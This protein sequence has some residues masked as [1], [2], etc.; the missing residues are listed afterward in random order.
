MFVRGRHSV[1]F[2]TNIDVINEVKSFTSKSL[3]T[4]DLAEANLVLNIKLTRVGLC[5][6]NLNMLTWSH[7]GSIDRKTSPPPY[8]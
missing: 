4:K 3:D 7:F 1:F 5:C 6:C 2:C 8:N